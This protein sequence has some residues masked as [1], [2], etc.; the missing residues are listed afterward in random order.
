MPVL[1]PSVRDIAV[2]G[3]LP[4]AVAAEVKNKINSVAETAKIIATRNKKC[5]RGTKAMFLS[6]TIINNPVLCT[7]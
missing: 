5:L 6:W 2:E 4:V 1:V 7:C 3:L